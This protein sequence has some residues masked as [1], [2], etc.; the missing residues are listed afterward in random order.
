MAKTNFTKVEDMLNQGLHKITVSHLL[1]EADA[2]KGSAPK[3]NANRALISA[4][5]RDLKLLHK[6]DHETY[7]KLGIKKKF[8][9]KIIETPESLTP[10]ELE[11]LKQIQ[12]KIKVFKEELK[13]KVPPVNDESIV[14]AER[15]KHI[16]KRYNV[17][18][19]WLPLQ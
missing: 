12:G 19:K 9:K 15:T 11:T 18:D 2:A 1:D 16:N 10:E 14:E 7:T 6:K 17:N 13:N 5:Q 8:L 3:D 4:L